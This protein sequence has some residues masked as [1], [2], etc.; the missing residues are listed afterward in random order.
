[1]TTQ[2]GTRTFQV[3]NSGYLSLG[4][5]K[6]GVYTVN[7]MKTSPMEEIYISPFNIVKITGLSMNYEEADEVSSYFPTITRCILSTKHT[8]IILN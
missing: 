7:C 8:T 2:N 1:M 6:V 4:Y 3:D 5:L